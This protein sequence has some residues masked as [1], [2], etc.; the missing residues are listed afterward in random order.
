MERGKSGVRL[1]II[2][3]VIL[4]VAIILVPIALY[5]ADIQADVAGVSQAETVAGVS[6]PSRAVNLEPTF[7]L[8][9]TDPD[10]VAR[11]ESLTGDGGVIDTT[12]VS[13]SD[14]RVSIQCDPRQLCLVKL[15]DDQG[16]PIDQITIQIQY[17]HPT[18]PL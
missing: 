8:N 15:F 12:T 14:D 13:A 7:T 9:L 17:T 4:F 3:F 5:T 16:R 2:V 10:Q 11:V 18:I 1:W 6:G